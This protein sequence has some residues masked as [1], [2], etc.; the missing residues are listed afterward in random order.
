MAINY[1]NK[2]SANKSLNTGDYWCILNLDIFLDDNSKWNTIRGQIN[3]GFIY[4]QSR[5]EFIGFGFDNGN[6]NSSDNNTNNNINNSKKLKENSK[7]DS[8]F[9]KMYHANTQDAWLFKT[10][11]DCNDKNIDYNFELGFLG[12]D[13]AIA[14][15]FMKSG[16]KVINQPLTYKIFHY[17]IAK[18]KTSSN[19]LEKHTKETKEKLSKMIKPKNGPCTAYVAGLKYLCL[20]QIKF[21]VF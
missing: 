1:A 15:R 3:N 19:F 4:A 21:M 9:A 8:N 20:F 12:C 14:E 5:H 18:G 11:L 6:G 7:M 16:Y 10:P 17:D 13:N 2:K